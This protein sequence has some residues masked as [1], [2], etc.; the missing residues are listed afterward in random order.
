MSFYAARAFEFRP[1]LRKMQRSI[2]IVILSTVLLASACSTAH[3]RKSADRDTAAVIAEKSPRLP[4]MDRHFTIEETNKLTLEDLL[5]VTEIEEALGRD[6]ESERGAKIISLERALDIAVNHSRIYQAQKE[7]LY[8]QALALTLAR[9]QFTPIFSGRAQ[10]D[11]QVVTEE[12]RVGID[13][14]TGAPK[15]IAAQ[16]ATLVEQ[17]RITAQG[18]TGASILLRSGARLAAAFSTDFLRYLT[19]DPRTF[20]ASQVGANIVQPLWRGA[21]YKVTMENLTQSERGLRRA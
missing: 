7:Q 5:R 20:T 2:L 12:V 19:G 17:H 10:T 6:G 16:D 3:Y 9:H 4:N 21:G 11:Y 15:A 8:L 18:S 1:P 13:A 14:I